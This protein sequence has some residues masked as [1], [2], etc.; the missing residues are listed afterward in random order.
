MLIN[1]F[2]FLLPVYYLDE[3]TILWWKFKHYFVIVI[4][5]II[6]QKANSSFLIRQRPLSASF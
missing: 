5:T 4:V 6:I 2:L 3:N 1:I